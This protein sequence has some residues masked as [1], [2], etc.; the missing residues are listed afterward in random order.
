MGQARPILEAKSNEAAFTAAGADGDPFLET[1]A[2]SL[3]REA[4]R[5][6]AWQMTGPALPDEAKAKPVDIHLCN[7]GSVG[8]RRRLRE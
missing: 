8:S 3:L 6:A 1:W 4:G 7:G 5:S 2:S